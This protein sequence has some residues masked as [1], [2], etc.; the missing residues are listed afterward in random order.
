[1]YEKVKEIVQFFDPT[2]YSWR[3]LEILEG[4]A[5]GL[6]LEQVEVYTETKYDKRQ[7]EIPKY[8]QEQIEQIQL[9]FKNNL[10]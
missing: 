1:M 7:G 3:T 6:T 10:T 9:G 2:V 4:I 5:N 8:D